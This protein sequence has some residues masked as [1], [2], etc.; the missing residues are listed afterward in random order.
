[1]SVH[2]D[3]G[4][5]SWEQVFLPYPSVS[6][7]QQ[8]YQSKHHFFWFM[9]NFEVHTLSSLLCDIS[10][11]SVTS[12]QKVQARLQAIV[13]ASRDGQV[14]LMFGQPYMLAAACLH[15]T[16]GALGLR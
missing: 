12:L 16:V 2:G 3:G 13:D 8:S 10:H 6:C 4:K 14:R 15:S 5:C 11:D 1:M 7:L 9:Q